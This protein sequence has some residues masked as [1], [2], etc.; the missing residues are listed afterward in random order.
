M[1]VPNV[2][3]TEYLIP[4]TT[5][6][7]ISSFRL[8]Y[9]NNIDQSNSMTGSDVP[10]C[11]NATY[12][13]RSAQAS[14]PVVR[15]SLAKNYSCVYSLSMSLRIGELEFSISGYKMGG[16]SMPDIDIYPPHLYPSYF[17]FQRSL[18]HASR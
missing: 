4:V 18:P 15:S 6:P 12:R 11:T 10:P 3:F 2:E 7:V 8:D 5:Y 1:T 16:V 14:F 17:A 9:I 13:L